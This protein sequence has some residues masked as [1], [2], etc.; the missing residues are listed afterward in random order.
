M[1]I[2]MIG[3]ISE[4]IRAERN[5]WKDQGKP[6]LKKLIIFT[7]AFAVTYPLMR[8]FR[9]STISVSLYHK[10]NFRTRLAIKKSIISK[11]YRYFNNHF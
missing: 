4:T 10:N 2:R 7:I 5:S 8:K 3:D 9:F 6:F 11:N 1:A